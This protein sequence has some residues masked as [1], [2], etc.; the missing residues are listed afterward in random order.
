MP[1]TDRDVNPS[2]IVS[3]VLME[4]VADIRGLRTDRWLTHRSMAYAQIRGLHTAEIRDSGDTT[5]RRQ[6][7]WSFRVCFVKTQEGA[8]TAAS[9]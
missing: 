2:N 8:P 3:P 5:A 9:F 7:L 4:F 1:S 6:G